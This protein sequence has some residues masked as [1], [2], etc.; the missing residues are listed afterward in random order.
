MSA[1]VV[2]FAYNRADKLRGCVESLALADG[3]EA[4]EVHIYAD[5]EKGEDDREAT[6][7]VGAYLDSLVAVHPFMSLKVTKREKNVGL[8]ANVISGVSEVMGEYGRAIVLE[9]DLLITG[10]FLTFMNEAM[11]YYEEDQRVWSV[12][13]YSEPLKSLEE[14]DHDIYYG[15]RGCSYGWGTWKDRWDTVDW[16][17]KRYDEVMNDRRLR[18][19]FE[20]GGRD[21][22]RILKDQKA[23]IVDSWAIRWCLSQSLQDR[24]TVY[25]KHSFI[26]NTGGDGSGTHQII[27]KHFND[28]RHTYGEK[29]V[30]EHLKPDE[31]ISGEFYRVHS[32]IIK[33]A[34]RSMNIRG[35]KRQI[36]RWMKNIR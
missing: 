19:R 4:A 28:N 27:S 14:Y 25:P 6:A 10:D 36:K 26:T 34:F 33:R 8:S 7:L 22:T 5:G 31:S 20:R 12:T 35:I 15:Y 17:M 13:G 21:M 9:D 1:P 32:D 23:G 29:M 24:Y 11:D 16:D 3:H 18:R 30:L 2:I